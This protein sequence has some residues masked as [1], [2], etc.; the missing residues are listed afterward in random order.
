MHLRKIL[1]LCLVL[2]SILRSAPAGL[3]PEIP[4]ADFF[5]LS[6]I[7]QMRFSP[8]GRFLAALQPWEKRQNL[9]VV[10]LRKMAKT[11][12]TSMKE[13]DVAGFLW[14][15]DD[16]IIFFMDE[17]GK[18][19]LSLYAVDADGRNPGPLDSRR[20]F[21]P[22]ARIHGDREWIVVTVAEH[23]PTLTD[24][25]HFNLRT[26]KIRLQAR[27]PGN[28]N[29]GWTVD[30]AGVAR[31]GQSFE[32]GVNTV[33]YR[34]NPKSEWEVLTTFRDGEQGW[35]P[36]EFDGDNRTLYVASDIDRKT[37]A[38]Y[39]YDTKTRT[40]GELVH[41]DDTYD[42]AEVIYSEALNRVTAVVYEG[43][44]P[45][46]VW[47]DEGFAKLQRS[48]DVTLPRTRNS[49]TAASAD[50]SKLLIGAGSDQDPGTYYLYDQKT[51]AMEKLAALKPGLRPEH[52]AP[53]TP[54][55]YRA[56]DGL[57]LHGYLTLPVGREA[58]GL[59]LIVHPHGGPY[60]P[61]DL[62]GFNPEVQFYA[63]RG[64][65]VLQINFRGSGGYGD[66]FER[67][68]HQKW[69][70]E[71]Q[72]DITDGVKW[73]IAQGIVD[74]AR[75]VISGASYG[76]Y[77]AMAGLVYTPELYCAGI[78]YVGV[79]DLMMLVDRPGL[80][81]NDARNGEWWRR[82][83]IGDPFK[84]KDRLKATS[85]INFA[86]QVRV[87][88]LMAYGENDPRVEI[89]HGSVLARRLKAAGRVEGRDFWFL[90]EKY[91]GHGF[92]KEEK[93]I[94]F[95]QEIDRFLRNAVPA[96]S[97]DVRLGPLEVLSMPAKPA[98]DN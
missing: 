88:L 49:I 20:G 36:V 4:V 64:F 9:I 25:Y 6:A 78:N 89:A 28:F 3:P 84:D 73:V 81:T 41:A 61:R 94:A 51:H 8:D 45:V 17:H 1:L 22:L 79:T 31:L 21:A 19:S 37:K 92:D 75:I 60:G 76:G 72:D 16:R 12:I 95:Y 42:V 69:G 30:H 85:P 90:T 27:N 68:G 67:A 18:E 46:T 50:N 43:E 11:Q 47:L 82:T 96:R 52:L 48:L 57:L 39:R 91:E 86:E 62:W 80:G 26:G 54:I 66:W 15:G 70:L 87:P 97:G 32:N 7:S 65:A 53:M 34:E 59:P 58:K 24:V 33:Y 44:R 29:N 5:G 35:T 55:T 10:D 98:G 63:N 13:N 40:M 38:I 23:R 83:R 56:R 74:P 2:V 77:A 93:R 14:A 71:M